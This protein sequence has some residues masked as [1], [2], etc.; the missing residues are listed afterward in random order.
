MENP[1]ITLRFPDSAAWKP[2]EATEEDAVVFRNGSGCREL[3]CSGLH[4][5]PS[6]RQNLLRAEGGMKEEYWERRVHF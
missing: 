3:G 1:N 5:G 6:E 2:S 4:S